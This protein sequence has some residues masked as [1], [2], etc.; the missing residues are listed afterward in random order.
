MPIA[1]QLRPSFPAEGLL[2]YGN[3]RVVAANLNTIVVSDWVVPAAP[4]L[5]II[6]VGST[7][8]LSWPTNKPGFIL[9]SSTNLLA[10]GSWNNLTFTP[11]ADGTSFVV[12]NSSDY[13]QNFFRLTR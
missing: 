10:P 2:A 3:R 8:L 1:W 9:Q 4:T 5:N 13:D 12:T 7:T 6:R 11:A